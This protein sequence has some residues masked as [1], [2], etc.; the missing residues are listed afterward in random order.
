MTDVEL[1]RGL[2]TDVWAP[3]HAAYVACDTDA[4]LALHSRDLIRAGGPRKV[5]QTYDEVAAETRPFF[6]GRPGGAWRWASSSGSPS[7]WRPAGWPAN[8][9]STGSRPA[10]TSSTAGSTRSAGT[11]GTRWQIVADHD[12]PEPDD[13][14][15]TAAHDPDDL[16]PFA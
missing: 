6:T 16:A 9:A 4:Y 13:R 1:L 14:A 8:G 7:G 2:N 3:F 10:T 11:P 15:F 12:V 5:V